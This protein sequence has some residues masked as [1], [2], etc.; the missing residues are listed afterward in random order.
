[1]RR[2]RHLHARTAA[3]GRRLFH[4][5]HQYEQGSISRAQLRRA[6]VALRMRFARLH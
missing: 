4:L 3:K 1:M 6:L 5:W 2:F